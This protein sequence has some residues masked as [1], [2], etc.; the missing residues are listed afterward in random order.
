MHEISLGT[1]MS[2][3]A[4]IHIGQYS[5]EEGF[6]REFYYHDHYNLNVSLTCRPSPSHMHY[7]D[8][9]RPDR[10]EAL[11]QIVLLPAGMRVRATASAGHFTALNCSISSKF[12]SILPRG[13]DDSVLV[14]LLNID[15]GVIR[16]EATRIIAEMKTPDFGSSLIVE[17]AT[18]ILAGDLCRYVGQHSYP[19]RKQGGL[20]PSKLRLINDRLRADLPFPRLDD[21]AAVCGLSPRHLSR[22]FRV[23]TGQTIREYIREASLERATRLLTSTDLAITKIAYDLGF[24][25]SSSFGFAFRRAKGLTPREVRKGR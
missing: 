3:H 16:R 10:W 11:G 22:A 6:N 19:A 1:V 24:S 13:L 14:R 21:L 2:P 25:S 23:E 8:V 7:S 4:E 5:L 12:F 9:W 18:M 20:A 17:G 15:A